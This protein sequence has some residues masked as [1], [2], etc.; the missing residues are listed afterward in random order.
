VYQVENLTKLQIRPDP[1]KIRTFPDI[2]NQAKLLSLSFLNTFKEHNAII[3]SRLL[4]IS[5]DL[6]SE[7]KVPINSIEVK[8]FWVALKAAHK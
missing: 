8:Q 6:L 1:V 7:I 5:D 2:L 4:L 3:I